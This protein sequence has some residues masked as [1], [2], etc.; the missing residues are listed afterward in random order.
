MRGVSTTV[1]SVDIELGAGT[2]IFVGNGNLGVCTVDKGHGN[3]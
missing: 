2:S 3:A 1:K